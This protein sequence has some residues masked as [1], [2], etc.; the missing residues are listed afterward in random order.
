[1]CVCVSII[2]RCVDFSEATEKIP[3]HH[4]ALRKAV[5]FVIEP[6]GTFMDSPGTWKPNGQGIG[7]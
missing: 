4:P 1:M 3:L 7:V 6:L 2:G 5:P